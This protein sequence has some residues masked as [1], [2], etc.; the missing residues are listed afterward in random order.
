MIDE[1]RYPIGYFKKP[2]SLGEGIIQ[3]WSDSIASFPERLNFL[4]ANLEEESLSKTYREEGWNVSQLIHHLADSHMNGY[5]RY[6]WAL[7]ED[8][9]IIKTYNEKAFAELGDSKSNRIESSA[10]ILEGLHM[11]WTRSING[12]TKDELER[13]FLHPEGNYP[14]KIYQIVALY[15]WHGDHHLAHIKNALNK[16]S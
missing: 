6:K 4:T 8:N 11:R 14:T 13:N 10:K 16:K 12:L 9:P 1:I 5:I 7:T 15:A 3:E 2:D